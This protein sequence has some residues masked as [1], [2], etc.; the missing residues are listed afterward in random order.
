MPAG[1]PSKYTK[2]LGRKICDRIANGESL[3]RVCER[4][5]MPARRTV[6]TWL[7]DEDKKQFLHNYESSVNIRTDNMFDAL[8]EISDIS[9]DSESP[10]RSRLRVDTRKWYLSKVMPKKYG[11]KIDHTTG[12]KPIPLLNLNAILRNNSDTQDSET[13][14]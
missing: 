5:D 13:E 8:E 4:D 1:R 2:E 10:M 12:G 9:D 3:K 6:H 7:L 11:D 14:E